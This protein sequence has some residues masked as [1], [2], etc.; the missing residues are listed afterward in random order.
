LLII[1][2]NH[3]NPN[4]F[5]T[6]NKLF[7]NIELIA[8]FSEIMIENRKLL[9][10]GGGISV[11]R[12]ERNISGLYWENEKATYQ[13]DKVNDFKDIDIIVSHKPIPYIFDGF[14]NNFIDFWVKGDA[15]L[16]NQLS[17][18]R[19]EA[20]RFINS[21]KKNNNIQLFISSHL[22]ISAQKNVDGTK[23]ISLTELEFWILNSG[24]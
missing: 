13:F 15:C 20:K 17:K 11:D 4:I 21:L 24:F 19:D 7:S 1:R 18:E 23:H 8:D 5:N 22:N 10:Y 12:I 6:S 2:G 16:E 9:L 3:D 14:L